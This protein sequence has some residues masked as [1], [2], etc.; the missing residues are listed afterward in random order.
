[1]HALI[2]RACVPGTRICQ[3]DHS[4]LKPDSPRA[5]R[6][7]PAAQWVHAV[8]QKR[9]GKNV[10]AVRQKRTRKNVHAVREQAAEHCS[11]SCPRGDFHYQAITKPSLAITKHPL[12]STQPL[13]SPFWPLPRHYQ[14]SWPLL[15]VLYKC[16]K[17]PHFTQCTAKP[18]TRFLKSPPMQLG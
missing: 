10:H 7:L 17:F 5:I 4:P 8:R 14:A 12:A 9:T 13:P 15:V 11:R 6:P 2:R 3:A 16:L 18:R 1:M